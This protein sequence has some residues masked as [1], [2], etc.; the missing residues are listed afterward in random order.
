MN[1]ESNI[2]DQLND[3]ISDMG[4]EIL[5]TICNN[6]GIKVSGLFKILKEKYNDITLDIIINIIKRELK[7]YI[8]LRGFRKTGGYY[9][10]F[11]GNHNE[12]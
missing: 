4:L 3:Q 10:K 12:Q 9:I 8:E 7:T 11:G 2:N 5:R 1:Y 6:E